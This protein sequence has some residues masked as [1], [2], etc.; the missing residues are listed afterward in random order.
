MILVMFFRGVIMENEEQPEWTPKQQELIDYFAGLDR[1]STSIAAYMQLTLPL[2]TV[3]KLLPL[4][5]I[6]CRDKD[7]AGTLLFWNINTAF[8]RVEYFPRNGQTRAALSGV[9]CYALPLHPVLE[10]SMGRPR[11][12]S[13]Q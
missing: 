10:L 9:N 13:T 6:A 8:P 7:P 4:A 3:R 1:I 12:E 2:E 11:S 5:D